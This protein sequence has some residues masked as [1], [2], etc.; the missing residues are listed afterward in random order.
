MK[1]IF[2]VLGDDEEF[3]NTFFEIVKARLDE[4]RGPAKSDDGL[5]QV[6]PRFCQ[7]SGQLPV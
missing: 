4:Q 7:V 1:K 6:R 2:E 3:V 5:D